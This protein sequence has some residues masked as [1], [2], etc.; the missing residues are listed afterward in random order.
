VLCIGGRHWVRF[1]S[2][3]ITQFSWILF[4]L[5]FLA[6]SNHQDILQFL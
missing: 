2:L 4:L 6:V 3:L 5:L 1:R